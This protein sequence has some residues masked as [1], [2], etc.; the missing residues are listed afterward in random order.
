VHW[1]DKVEMFS[2]VTPDQSRLEHE[3]LLTWERE[4][5]DKLEL[6]YRVVD[7]A[8]GDLG[9][10]AARKFDIEAWFPSQG[11]YREISSTSNCTTFQARRLNIRMRTKAG[12][13]TPVATLN[14]TLCAVAR[15]IACLLDHHQQPDGTVYVPKALRPWLGGREVLAP[16]LS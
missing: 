1:F 6:A 2:Y 11:T 14:G 4:F 12:S 9:A 13:T 3:R 8:G 16:G 5:F 15:T 7:I 10:S